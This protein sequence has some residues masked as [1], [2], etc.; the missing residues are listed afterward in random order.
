MIELPEAAVLARQTNERI[1]GKTI[2]NVTAAHSPHELVWY[3]GDPLEYKGLLEGKRVDGS[4]SYGGQ[5]EIAAGNARL[6]FGDGVN[7]RYFARGE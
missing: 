2:G 6:L 4:A 5:V 1:R 3:C 7:L